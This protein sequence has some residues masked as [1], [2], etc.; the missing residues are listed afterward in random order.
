MNEID[1]LRLWAD[2][3]KHGQDLAPTDAVLLELER[4]CGRPLEEVRS[5]ANRSPHLTKEIWEAGDRSTAEGLKDF[6]DHVDNWIY[7][8]LAYHAR[9]AEGENVP[10]P[11]RAAVML[12]GRPPGDFL[13]FGAGVATAS[14]LFARLGWRVT[15][16]DI[17]APL[18]DF[19]RWRFQD[20]GVDATVIDLSQERL[21]NRAFDVICAFNTMGHVPDPAATL[22]DL[23]RALRPHGLLLFD[24]DSR[25][26]SEGSPWHLYEHEYPMARAIRR[27][28]F[29]MLPK[30]GPMYVCRREETGALHRAVVGAYDRAR[31]SRLASWGGDQNRKALRLAQTALAGRR[32]GNQ[33]SK[34]KPPEL[35]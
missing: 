35:R 2:I 27:T 19:A 1:A 4:Y 15:S 29:V 23:R 31:Y 6:Y 28:G 11:V 22:R 10:L 20:R 30:V 5:L 32:P 25:P 16:A 14:L 26:R 8:T 3:L 33:A 13:D 21:R 17:S 18:L 34:P 9:Q 24:V 12:D 7:G